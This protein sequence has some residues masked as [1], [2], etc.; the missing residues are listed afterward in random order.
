MRARLREVLAQFFAKL[1]DRAL[2]WAATAIFASTLSAVSVMKDFLASWSLTGP[3]V[4]IMCAVAFFILGRRQAQRAQHAAPAKIAEPSFQIEGDE[5]ETLTG[6]YERFFALTIKNIE[7]T[8]LET[9]C[10]V[11]IEKFSATPTATM[12]I[13]F[14]LRTDGQIRG[15]RMGR[16]TLSAGQTKTIPVLFRNP[17]RRNEWFLFDEHGKRHFVPA[18]DAQMIIGV[19]GGKRNRSV[20]VGIDLGREWA[21]NFSLKADHDS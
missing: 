13:P 17:H 18:Q 14:V 9:C 12:P 4:A 15:Q 8:D 1:K 2:E 5:R 21:T 19:Y 6:D 11:Q 7:P 16:F 20:Q 3:I 10:L